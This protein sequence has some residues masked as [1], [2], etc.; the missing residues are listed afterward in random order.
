MRIAIIFEN[1]QGGII[2]PI[3]MLCLKF[4]EIYLNKLPET[5]ILNIHRLV[6]IDLVYDILVEKIVVS[7]LNIKACSEENFKIVNLRII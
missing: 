7:F 2:Q 4:H 5:I 6:F 1:S 3:K